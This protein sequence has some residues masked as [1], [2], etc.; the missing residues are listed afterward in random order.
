MSR[1]WSH[2][3]SEN[4]QPDVAFSCGRYDAVMGGRETTRLILVVAG[5]LGAAAGMW[6]LASHAPESDGRVRTARD[7][8]PTHADLAAEAAARQDW[9]RAIE[10]QTKWVEESPR[11]ASAL[12]RLGVYFAA[13]G[14]RESAQE[15]WERAVTMQSRVAQTRGR[16]ADWY[17]LAGFQASAGHVEEAIESLSRAAEAGWG[18]ADFAMSDPYLA[19]IRDHPRFGTIIDMM[20][21]HRAEGRTGV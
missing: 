17:R 12:H 20:R 6:T 9:G 11:D 2:G 8:K 14:D 21:T 10:H 13:S 4:T 18:R 1:T 5:V 15:S 3:E 16:A 7:D 19:P